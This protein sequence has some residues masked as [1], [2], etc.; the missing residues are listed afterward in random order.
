MEG[1]HAFF[2][3]TPAVHSIDQ[4]SRLGIRLGDI[5][6]HDAMADARYAPNQGH[7]DP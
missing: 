3:V 4:L 6:R 5:A 2:L 1:R 7:D